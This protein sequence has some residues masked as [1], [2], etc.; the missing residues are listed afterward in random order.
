MRRKQRTL[1]RHRYELHLSVEHR[2]VGAQF[3][4]AF[5]KLVEDPLTMLL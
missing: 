1:G 2:A 3:L 5:K 4:T